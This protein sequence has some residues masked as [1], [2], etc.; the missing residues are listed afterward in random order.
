[1]NARDITTEDNYDDILGKYEKIL[2]YPDDPSQLTN[3]QLRLFIP[4]RAKTRRWRN[5]LN[6]FTKFHKFEVAPKSN[7]EKDMNVTN[8]RGSKRTLKTRNYIKSQQ[9]SERLKGYKIMAYN[10]LIGLL[11][12]LMEKANDKFI[13][14]NLYAKTYSAGKSVLRKVD[15]FSSNKD[16][17]GI[18][19]L[20]NLTEEYVNNVLGISIPGR[21]KEKLITY[22]TTRSNDYDKE[23]KKRIYHVLAIMLGFVGGV[24]LLARYFAGGID[25][26]P[27]CNG[28]DSVEN[29][30]HVDAVM[31]ARADRRGLSLTS[32]EQKL[33][34][35]PTTASTDDAVLCYNAETKEYYET[36]SK[37]FYSD[38]KADD[39]FVNHFFGD[40]PHLPG[41][42]EITHYLLNLAGIT[43]N[44]MESLAVTASLGTVSAVILA[45]RIKTIIQKKQ[46]VYYFKDIFKRIHT[47]LFPGKRTDKLDNTK[48]KVFFFNSLSENEQNHLLQKGSQIDMNTDDDTLFNYIKDFLKFRQERIFEY[49]LDVLPKQ[50]HAEIQPALKSGKLTY[51]KLLRWATKREH[52]SQYRSLRE[53]SES[54]GTQRSEGPHGAQRNLLAGKAPILRVP[55]ATIQTTMNPLLSSLQHIKNTRGAPQPG[56]NTRRRV[57]PPP[58]PPGY[59]GTYRSPVTLRVPPPPP[60]PGYKGTYGSPVTLRVPPPP[61]PPGYKGTYRSPVTLRNSSTRPASLANNRTLPLPS[62]TVTN[63]TQSGQTVVS[64]TIRSQPPPPSSPPPPTARRSQTLK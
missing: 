9:T 36:V 61:P 2:G 23:P 42:E 59:K 15:Y 56:S 62:A 38:I 51:E 10:E 27:G 50:R 22:S 11:L 13:A 57:P 64:P 53:R 7:L 41:K 48:D 17:K 28:T 40:I 6:P 37:S 58:P 52:G 29:K 14:D 43:L 32:D 5:Y 24:A 47:L 21:L 63:V 18:I 26:A 8:E 35:W 4:P 55:Q 45:Y 39:I 49:A 33:V 46:K 20:S 1:M 54:P 16:E 25:Y 12:I 3:D 44:A 34:P 30:F 19:H 60:P 31:D